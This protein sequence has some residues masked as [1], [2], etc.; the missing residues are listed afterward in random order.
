LALKNR[1][2]KYLLKSSR[3]TMKVLGTEIRRRNLLIVQKSYTDVNLLGPLLISH[4]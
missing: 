3:V 4:F 1:N 2:P